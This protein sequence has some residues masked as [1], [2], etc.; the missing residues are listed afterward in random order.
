MPGGATLWRNDNDQNNY[1]QVKLLGAPP[2]TEAAGARI[3]VDI[4]G[5]TQMREVSIASNYVSQNPTV[6]HFGLGGATE[7]DQLTVE[8]PD[9]QTTILNNVEAGQLVEIAEQ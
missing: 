1:L 5:T 9:G 6:Q 8:W 7:V 4:G 3:T 2:N